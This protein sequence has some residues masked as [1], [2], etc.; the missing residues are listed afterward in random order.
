MARRWCSFQAGRKQPTPRVGDSDFL[1]S[2]S[3]YD[4]GHVADIL[5]TAMEGTGVERFTL[6]GHDVGTWIAYA[7]AT[8]RPAAI[9]RLCLTD[10]TIP[11][12]T[13]DAVYGIANR[14]KVFQFFFNALEGLPETLT[15]GREREFLARFFRTKTV[16]KNAIGAAD[17][18]EYARSYS[19]PGRM[20]A[21]FAFCRAVPATMV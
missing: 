5:A 9:E 21:G 11:G 17:L 19:R 1:P 20:S 2:G 16:V 8:R 15:E 18:E 3:L 4:T 10:S 6:V 13:T 7:W 14:P 12:V